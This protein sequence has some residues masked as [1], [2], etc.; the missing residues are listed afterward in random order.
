MSRTTQDWTESTRRIRKPPFDTP[1]MNL[2][3]IKPKRISDQV[4]EQIRELIY[5]GEL[6]GATDPS[7]KGTGDVDGGQPHLGAQRHQ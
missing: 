5:K 4:F 7:G 6:A 3:P 1:L 2:K